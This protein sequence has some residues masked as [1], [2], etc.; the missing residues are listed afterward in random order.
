MLLLLLNCL[1]IF[2]FSKQKGMFRKPFLIRVYNALIDF[3][4]SIVSKHGSALKQLR[5]NAITGNLFLST[6]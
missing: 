6:N 1:T 5:E 2:C 3:H 4:E